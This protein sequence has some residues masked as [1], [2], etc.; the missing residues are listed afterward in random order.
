MFRVERS[1]QAKIK[2]FKFKHDNYARPPVRDTAANQRL[3]H[4]KDEE[5][6][7]VTPAVNVVESHCSVV[8]GWCYANFNSLLLLL[9]LLLPV[10]RLS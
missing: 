7:Q 1:T 6:A 2:V 8:V 9:L 10:T 4:C 3:D 5:H